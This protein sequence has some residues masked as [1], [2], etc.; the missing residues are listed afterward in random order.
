MVVRE[1][2]TVVVSEKGWMRAMRGHVSD[3]PAWPSSPTTS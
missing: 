1:P 2:I 3:L